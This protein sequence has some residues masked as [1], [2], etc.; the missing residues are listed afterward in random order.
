MGRILLIVLALFVLVWLLRGVL[1]TRKR[2]GSRAQEKL[3]GELVTC[4]QCGVHLPRAEA[5]SAGGR[6]YCSEEHR[7]LGPREVE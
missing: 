6:S 1:L 5:R 7:R 4:A 2:D 3:T